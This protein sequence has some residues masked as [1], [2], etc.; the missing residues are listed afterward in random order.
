MLLDFESCDF[1]LSE[2]G[3]KLRLELSY[4][5]RRLAFYSC[6]RPNRF[7]ECLESIC[8]GIHE[9]FQFPSI[10]DDVFPFPT[11]RVF[12]PFSNIE[13]SSR[14]TNIY[15]RSLDK[16]TINLLITSLRS[17][18]LLSPVEPIFRLISQQNMKMC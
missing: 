13:N 6:R 10:V 1:E 9:I 2:R 4:D 7:S 5:S 12:P 15:N 16:N 11:R 14:T 18:S 8:C 17:S 3:K